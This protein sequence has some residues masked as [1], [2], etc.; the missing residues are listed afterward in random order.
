MLP[1]LDVELVA[2]VVV[3]VV[4]GVLVEELAVGVSEMEEICDLCH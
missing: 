3:A 4:V 2:V 1:L